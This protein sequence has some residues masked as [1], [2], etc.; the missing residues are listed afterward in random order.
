[1]AKVFATPELDVTERAVIELIGELRE[2]MRPLVAETRGWSGGLRRMSE[3]RAVQQSNSI[4]GYNATLDDVIAVADGDEPMDASRE[5]QLA[6]EGY[7]E[8]MTYVLQATQDPDLEVDEGVLRA[9]HFMM[10]KHDLSKNPGRWRPGAVHV[11]RSD[12]GEVVYEGPSADLVP[13]LVTAMLA[14]SDSDSETPVLVK[15][16]MAHL[17]LVMIHPFS[18]GNGRMA[19]CVQTLV[20]ARERIVAPVFSSIEE[21]LGRNT[22]SYYDVLADVGQGSWHPE[23]DARPWVRFCLTA[24]Y[25]QARTVLRR[26]QAFEEMW[27]VASNIAAEHKLPERTIGPIAEAAYGLRIRRAT[28][29]RVVE[30]TWGEAI[31]GLTGSRD[32]RAL[33]NAGL[34]IPIG[35]TRGRY[36][37]GTEELKAE[38]QRIRSKWPRGPEADDPF[39]IVEDRAQMRLDVG[40][41]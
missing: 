40:F 27:S 31:A 11:A 16:A 30:T 29:L 39:R 36:Y 2:E 18:D 3:A 9:L 32:L 28:Y 21:Y 7:Q 26:V 19:R 1:M 12:T 5:T 33:V 13:E 23:N 8:A 17:N 20:L 37:V 22:Q 6:L 34:F 24:H 38:W 41:R 4:E 35:D 10:I 25:R 15:A 14:A